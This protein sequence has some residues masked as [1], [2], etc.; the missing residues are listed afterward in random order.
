MNPGAITFQLPLKLQL[1]CLEMVI[2]PQIHVTLFY[3]IEVV[4]AMSE[5]VKCIHF[6]MLF[7]M[8]SFFLLANWVGTPIFP[9]KMVLKLM[10]M[11]LHKILF[12]LRIKIVKWMFQAKSTSIYHKLST[13]TYQLQ[14]CHNKTLH[15]N[16]YYRA[17]KHQQSEV[18]GHSPGKLK[19]CCAEPGEQSKPWCIVTGCKLVGPYSVC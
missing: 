7:M 13:S 5:L 11:L 19:T 9:L 8:F 15:E 16:L 1:Y 17:V 12:Q 3:S 4:K 2:S 14:P 6:T 18:Q 10:M